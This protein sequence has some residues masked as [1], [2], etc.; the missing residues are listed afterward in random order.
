M[1]TYLDTKDIHVLENK[2][3]L[4]VPCPDPQRL[5]DVLSMPAVRELLPPAL[6]GDAS[7]ARAQHRGLARF[8]GR[9]AEAIKTFAL[10]WGI[11][12][13]PAGLILFALG[14]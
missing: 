13:I 1:R 6:V 7:A 12:L 8:T 2:P 5:A 9:A 14:F 3:K 4:Y 11:S 10:R